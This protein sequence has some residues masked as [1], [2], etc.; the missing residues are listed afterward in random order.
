MF[1]YEA[2]PDDERS[3]DED[4]YEHAKR[5]LKYDTYGLDD[6]QSTKLRVNVLLD[7][8]MDQIRETKKKFPNKFLI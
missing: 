8:I 4:L 2:N 3:C 7:Q 6:G 5:F 1:D